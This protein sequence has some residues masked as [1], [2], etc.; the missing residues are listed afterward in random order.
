MKH[1]TVRL[2]GYE[3]PLIGVPPSATEETCADCGRKQ[4][5]SEMQLDMAFR[6]ICPG[7][8]TGE[9]IHTFTIGADGKSITC[10]RCHRTSHNPHDVQHHYCGGCH[11]FHDDLWPPAR[12][13]WLAREC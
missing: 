11:M 10:L 2:A 12:K 9:G 7:C 1:A 5:L 3:I 4:H 6:P 8:L 13:A